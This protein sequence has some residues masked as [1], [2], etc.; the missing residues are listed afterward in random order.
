MA[1]RIHR[2]LAVGIWAA[3][4]TGAAEEV[5]PTA[6]AEGADLDA[7][8]ASD[9]FT[10][11]TLNLLRRRAA[12]SVGLAGSDVDPGQMQGT[13][14]I[15]EPNLG[16]AGVK[17]GM[18]MWSNDESTVVGGACQFANKQTGGLRAKSARS[19]YIQNRG[20]CAVNSQRWRGG[21]ACGECYQISYHGEAASDPGRPG[22][23][24][25]QVVDSGADKDFDCEL[26]AFKKATGSVTG[27]FP[28][29]FK[30]V[31][32]NVAPG[33]M[34]AT[35]LASNPYFLIVI[36]ANSA[37][38]VRKAT[39]TVGG[40]KFKMRRRGATFS[41]ITGGAKGDVD[42]AV[43]A[44]DGSAHSFSSCFASWPQSI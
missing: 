29:T 9:N 33:G 28:I 21:D 34:T 14:G 31:P 13:L 37:S 32:C 44:A 40:K 43:V 36:F 10:D 6:W 17:G 18:T 24:E 11:S 7:A 4:S 3:V 38:P 8:R 20:Y 1:A 39:L 23:V 30:Q 19:P 16:A 35:V 25:I 26:P 41:V 12:T 22:S 15:L 5:P 2:V 27:I 42:F